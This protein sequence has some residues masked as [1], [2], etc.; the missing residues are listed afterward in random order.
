MKKLIPI[1]AS[2]L[3]AAHAQAEN[4]TEKQG[5]IIHHNALTTDILTPE[6]A[7]RNNVQRSRN[8]AMVNISVQ[9]MV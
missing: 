3:L 8:R 9:K 4:S 7:R 1:I 6:I 2:L 5:Y